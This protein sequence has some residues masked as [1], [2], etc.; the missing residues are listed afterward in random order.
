LRCVTN[1]ALSLPE[2]GTASHRNQV[3]LSCTFVQYDAAGMRREAIDQAIAVRA[4][5]QGGVAT[6]LAFKRGG[7]EQRVTR[8]NARW[9][10]R[11]SRHPHFHF[12]VTVESGDVY[13]LQFSG[14][15]LV[16]WLESVMLEG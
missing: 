8:V 14:A 12:S 6:P 9:V 2:I 10:D 5:F 16:W 7:R 3:L 13:Q 4:D 15:D 11:A 1:H